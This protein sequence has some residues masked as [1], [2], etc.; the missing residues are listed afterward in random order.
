[1]RDLRAMRWAQSQPYWNGETITT[2]GS[3]GGFQ[4]M[5]MAGMDP[6]VVVA[7]GYCPWYVD[8]GGS[9]VHWRP[10]AGVGPA[11][12]D[13]VYWMSRTKAKKVRYHAGLIDTACPC[14][15][16]IAMFNAIPDTCEEAEIYLF[17]SRG[18][19]VGDRVNYPRYRL[20]KRFGK[21]TGEYLP[22]G[23]APV[24]CDST[25]YDYEALKSKS[26]IK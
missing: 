2:G 5:A 10:L 16:E 19:D 20:T 4:A 13:P 3:Q 12:A 25:V 1:M 6:S 24:R 18:H 11:Y 21:V 26:G 14:D 23:T 8:V 9:Q 7:A 17:Q 15:G 22:H